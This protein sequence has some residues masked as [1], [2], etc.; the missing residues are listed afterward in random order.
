[1]SNI[2]PVRHRSVPITDSISTI[3]GG[4]PNKL[5]IFQLPASPF[6]WVRYYSN[7]KIVKKSTKTTK[8]NEA[9]EFAK[10][11]YEDTL[12]RERNLLPISQSPSFEKFAS[13][14]I[15]E[16]EQL[17][18]RGERSKK[19]NVND[20]QILKKD[21]LPFFRG[22]DVRGVTHQ[23][24]NKYLAKVS[25]RD[26]KGATL[27]THLNLIR[28]ILN[29]AEREGS[30]DRLPKF[31]TIKIK[32]GNRT[33]FTDADYKLLKQT[34]SDAIKKK[35][36]VRGHLITDEM[37]L[38]ITFMVNTFLRPSDIKNLR[39]R[40]I[41]IIE[42]ENTYLRISPEESKTINTPIVSME[43]AVGIYRDLVALHTKTKKPKGLEDFVFLPE[44]KNRD[45][46]L[47]TLRRQFEEL[48]GRAKLKRTPSGEVRTLYSL[49]HTSI[50]F[51]LTKGDHIDLLTLARNARTSVDM[52]EKFYA[53]V[54]H[55]IWTSSPFETGHS[56]HG[57]LINRSVATLGSFPFTLD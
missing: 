20:E 52:I 51:R 31:P 46:A 19:L 47:Q 56:V 44:I 14:L 18:S 25:E 24:I 30:I 15:D 54:F 37:R 27:K 6:W 7:R 34:V 10:K 29:L 32:D 53:W 42:G 50:M 48:L 41:E 35:I 36:N 26:L 5:I 13:L 55:G 21:M 39:N 22:F 3:P 8:K 45:F 1:M 17:I 38:L 57:K 28:K 2:S 33:W 12:L 23:H 49:R 16:Q 9:I 11:F 4:Y 43:D 40:N